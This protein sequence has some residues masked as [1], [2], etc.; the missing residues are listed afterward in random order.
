MKTLEQILADL[1]L[2]TGTILSVG[3]DNPYQ[4]VGIADTLLKIAQAA[5]KGHNDIVGEPLDLDKL[6]PID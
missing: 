3:V 2:V 4:I 6:Q 1:E 5:V